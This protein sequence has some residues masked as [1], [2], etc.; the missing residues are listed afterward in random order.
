MNL[1]EIV[2]RERLIDVIR[3]TP[4]D[5]TIL[6]LVEEADGMKY[7]CSGPNTKLSTLNWMISCFADYLQI[8]AKEN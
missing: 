5:S 7:R 3:S 8:L 4:E 1:E 6:L 2:S